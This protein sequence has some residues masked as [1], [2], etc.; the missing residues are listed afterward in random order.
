MKNIFYFR[1][2]NAIGGIESFF[3]DV[4]NNF[5]SINHLIKKEYASVNKSNPLPVS[6][7]GFSAGVSQFPKKCFRCPVVEL[8]IPADVGTLA[9]QT[10]TGNIF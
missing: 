8:T 10:H 5:P 6:G 7:S 1:V 9:A 3:Y 4:L 2:I